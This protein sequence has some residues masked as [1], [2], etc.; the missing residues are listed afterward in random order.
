MA[1]G[2]VERADL[3]RALV[4]PR[5]RKQNR[6]RASGMVNSLTQR[7]CVNMLRNRSRL[8]TRTHRASNSQEPLRRSVVN[9]S[10]EREQLDERAAAAGAAGAAAA[11]GAVA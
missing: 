9:A 2:V 1:D 8:R 5:P 6:S 10:G 7:A 4:S 11:G 3:N